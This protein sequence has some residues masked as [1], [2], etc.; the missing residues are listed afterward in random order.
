MPQGPGQLGLEERPHALQG[1][2]IMG[3]VTFQAMA[4]LGSVFLTGERVEMD[5]KPQLKTRIAGNGSELDGGATSFH[6]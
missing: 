1:L 3:N 6:D 2:L 5:Q 4:D